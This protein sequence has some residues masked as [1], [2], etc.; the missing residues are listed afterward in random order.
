MVHLHVVVFGEYI[1]QEELQRLWSK[2]LGEKLAIV[3]I[4]AVRDEDPR[5]IEHALREVLKYAT[6]GHGR[7]HEQAQRAAAVEFAFRNVHRISIGGAL[8]KIRP[9]D[10]AFEDVRPEELASL[11]FE[12]PFEGS[13]VQPKPCAACGSLGPWRLIGFVSEY[14][15]ITNGGFGLVQRQHGP[16]PLPPPAGQSVGPPVKSAIQALWR[17]LSKRP[18]QAFAELRERANRWLRRQGVKVDD[19][20][21]KPF[22]G[23]SDHD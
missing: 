5:Q 23:C 7:V 4:R 19:D 10:S 1:S 15:V 3:D 6:K 9:G 11:Q 12:N 13:E 16:P 14:T 21:T 2:A 22:T 8:L 17:D 18:T 20:S